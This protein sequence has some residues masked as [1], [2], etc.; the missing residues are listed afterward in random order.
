MVNNFRS[1][2]MFV[3][4]KFTKNWNVD[5]FT[6][7]QTLRMMSKIREYDGCLGFVKMLNFGSKAF[8][9][10]EFV[11]RID[12]LV[13]DIQHFVFR[14]NALFRLGFDEFT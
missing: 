13:S 8:K 2:H 12:L 4:K 3:G 11:P 1:S 9:M 6:L 5:E 7:Q 14:K 10:L